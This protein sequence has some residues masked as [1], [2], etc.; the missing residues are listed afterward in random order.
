MQ[1]QHVEREQWYYVTVKA[2]VQ[3]RTLLMP[4]Q[5][6]YRTYDDVTAWVEEHYDAAQIHEVIVMEYL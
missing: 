1:Q 5:P 6:L 4:T 3:G 2:S